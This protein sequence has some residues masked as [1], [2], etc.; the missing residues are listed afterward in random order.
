MNRLR[1][2]LWLPLFDDVADPRVVAR[3]AADAHDTGDGVWFDS[4]AW[5]VTAH[6]R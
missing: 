6:R 5:L 1:S 4:R 2:A 3:L